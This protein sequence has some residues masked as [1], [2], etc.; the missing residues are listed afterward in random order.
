MKIDALQIL[1]YRGITELMLTDLDPR[2]N[3]FVGV[4]GAGKS[5]ILD[6]IKCLLQR[7]QA[8]TMD[9]RSKVDLVDDDVQNGKNRTDLFARV[10]LHGTPF[11]LSVHY[12][13]IRDHVMCAS[14]LLRGVTQ[15]N[16]SVRSTVAQ[17][18]KDWTPAPAPSPSALPEMYPVLV[19]YPVTRAVLDIPERTKKT[20]EFGEWSAWTDSLTPFAADFRTFFTWFRQHEDLENEHRL[21][22]SS[23]RDPLL[24]SVRTAIEALL[25]GYTDLKIR[26]ASPVRMTMK[27]GGHEIALQQFSDGEK[28]LIALIGD[29]A[30]RLALANLTSNDP[31]LGAGIVL[32]DEL[33]LHLHPQWQI[34][35]IPRL[36]Q[37]FPNCQFFVSTHSPLLV[38]HANPEQVYLL[39]A[40]ETVVT[41][42]RPQINPYGQDMNLV[43]GTFMGTP[44]REPQTQKAL[45]EI[46]ATLADP[47]GW[48]D[49]KDLIQAL[50]KSNPDL[51]DLVKAQ[52][53]LERKELLAR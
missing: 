29:L 35:I 38:S 28:C 17:W 53:I 18:R 42:E 36:L 20:L 13:D 16:V 19:H 51:P 11:Q 31:L 3:V 39:D 32:I 40:N 15:E 25:P 1:G 2:L 5:S 26:R 33:D 4:N 21:E 49:A 46:F 12:G 7:F 43:V 50:R 24:N 27:K 41:A 30:R 47:E 22:S 14:E 9:K 45:Q 48:K 34:E 44:V 23:Y 37:T 6:A 8:V 52:A 10:T